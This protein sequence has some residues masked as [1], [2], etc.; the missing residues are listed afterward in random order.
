MVQLDV[1]PAQRTWLQA[2]FQGGDK[3]DQE[4]LQE[5]TCDADDST[6]EPSLWIHNGVR[7][8]MDITAVVRLIHVYD[9]SCHKLYRIQNLKWNNKILNWSM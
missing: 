1:V 6:V 9:T 8:T 5:D 3:G 4:G 7:A 2:T